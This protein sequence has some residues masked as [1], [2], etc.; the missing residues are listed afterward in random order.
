VWSLQI[1]ILTDFLEAANSATASI[2]RSRGGVHVESSQRARDRDIPSQWFCRPSKGRALGHHGACL[3]P[4]FDRSLRVVTPADE[5]ARAT[6]SFKVWCPLVRPGRTC[7]TSSEDLRHQPTHHNDKHGNTDVQTRTKTYCNA[8]RFV[9]EP[10]AARNN[11][12]SE[13]AVSTMSSR[14]SQE[15]FPLSRWTEVRF[16]QRFIQ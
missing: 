7:S 15:I 11:R 10:K 1:G 9:A 13:H 4:L 14:C 8:H 3:P 6:M 5:N 12:E 2:G 16:N